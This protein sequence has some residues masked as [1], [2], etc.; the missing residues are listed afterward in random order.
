MVFQYYIPT[1]VLFGLGQLSQLHQQSLP[2]KKAFIVMSAG[3]SAR[4]FGYLARVEEQLKLAGVGY[5]TFEKIQPNP[6]KENVMEGAALARQ[7]GCDFILGLGG[8][9]S[10]DAAKAIAIMAVNDGDYWDYIPSG[11]GK[12]MAISHDPLPIVAI[13]MTAGTGTES[14]PWTVVTNEEKNEK[15]GYGYEKTFPTLAVMDAELTVS[16]PPQLTAFQGFDVFFHC[17]ESYLHAH[18]TPISDM[19][20]LKGISLVGEFLP[21]AI[22]DGSNMKAREEMMLANLMAAFVQSTAGC[23]SQ[24]ALEHA[25]S[26]YYPSLPHGAGLVL[27]S[28]EYFTFLAQS[29]TCDQRLIDMAVCLGHKNARTPMDFVK[30]LVD[31][32]AAC[33]VDTLKMSDYGIQENEMHKFSKNARYTM[34]G[35]FEVDPCITSEEACEEI[36]RKSYR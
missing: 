36:Y 2:G 3:Q 17:A 4:K 30:T 34:G 14:D 25:L 7:T 33:G 13:C 6:T 35:M 24:H 9:S 23:I 16:V 31:L 29:G 10:I 5:E 26:A 1:K 19:Y 20:S 12:G 27:L 11:S 22:K 18:T 15:I 28:K 8:G 21:A 32:Q